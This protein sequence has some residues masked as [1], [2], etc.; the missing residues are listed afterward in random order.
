MAQCQGRVSAH[1]WFLKPAEMAES[2]V[3][4]DLW[5]TAEAIPGV[6]AHMDKDGNEARCF[7]ARTS[8][9]TLLYDSA[10]A[11]LFQGGITLSRGHAGDNPGRTAITAMLMHGLSGPARTPVFG[12]AL[13]DTECQREGNACQH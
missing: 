3:K 10:G 9:Q 8:G 11:L 12:C 13:A 5:R 2:W 7:S 1:V 4:T 6:I